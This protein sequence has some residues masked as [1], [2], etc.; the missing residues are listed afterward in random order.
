MLGPRG[1]PHD[2]NVGAMILR[3]N[4]Y[5]LQDIFITLEPLRV[6]PFQEARDREDMHQQ[7]AKTLR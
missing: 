4:P 6:A 1:A 3:G 5:H 7:L 2:G